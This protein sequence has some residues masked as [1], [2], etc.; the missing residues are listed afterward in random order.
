MSSPRKGADF[1]QRGFHKCT[2]EQGAAKGQSPL[3]ST[4][5]ETGLFFTNIKKAQFALSKNRGKSKNNQNLI[6]C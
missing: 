6:G 1:P 3:A 2:F 4:S 5:Y